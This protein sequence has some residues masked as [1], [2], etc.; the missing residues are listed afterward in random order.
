MAMLTSFVMLIVT[1]LGLWTEVAAVMDEPVSFGIYMVAAI[2]YLPALWL[3]ISMAVL[4]VGWAPKLTSLSWLLLL[5]SFVVVYLG[6]LLQ[7]PDWLAKITPYGHISQYPVEE[8]DVMRLLVLAVVA[9][10]ITVVGYVG[11]SKRDIDG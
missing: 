8:I 7:F 3:M 4:L 2:S 5:Y 10:G 11:Y 1:A 6:G 9:M